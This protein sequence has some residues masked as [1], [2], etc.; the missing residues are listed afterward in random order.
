MVCDTRESTTCLDYSRQKKRCSL[1]L[2]V[3]ERH[4][5][6]SASIESCPSSR[7]SAE[8]GGKLARYLYRFPELLRMILGK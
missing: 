8:E 1:Q 7:S 5:S 3:S 4:C 6:V 2:G